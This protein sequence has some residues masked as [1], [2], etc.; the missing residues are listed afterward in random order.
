M[1]FDNMRFSF[2]VLLVAIVS[3]C[4]GGPTVQKFVDGISGTTTTT[5]TTIKHVVNAS[6][7]K[8]VSTDI[9]TVG[10]ALFMWAPYLCNYTNQISLGD[11]SRTS[12]WMDA[13][14]Y[15]AVTNHGRAETHVIND[16]AYV[17]IWEADDH[18]GTKYRISEIIGLRE[19]IESSEVKSNRSVAIPTDYMDI[20]GAKNVTCARTTL[21][22]AIFN[23]PERLPFG[24]GRGT[25]DYNYD[26]KLDKY[27]KDGSI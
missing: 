27:G 7:S 25:Y 8:T 9:K 26:S 20:L 1:R 3:G 24:P 21:P 10:E 18:Q 16:R 4:L 12:V 14:K 13:G 6:V 22:D 2:A 19:H 5:S 23:P 11:R 17:Y 15:H